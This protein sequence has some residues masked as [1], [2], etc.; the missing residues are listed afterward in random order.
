MRNP[1]LCARSFDEK[2]VQRIKAQFDKS[3]VFVSVGRSVDLE[4]EIDV[5]HLNYQ[6]IVTEGIQLNGDNVLYLPKEVENTQ[7]YIKAFEMVITK[8]GFGTVAETMLAKKK[9]AVIGRETVA[10][11]R[12]TVDHLV[13]RGLAIQVE[14][15]GG[16]DM[17]GI[18]RNLQAFEPRY[19][20]NPFTNDV[21]KIARLLIGHVLFELSSF[22]SLVPL[23]G[24]D[25]PFEVKRVF[26]LVDVEQG[27]TRENHAYYKTK[28]VLICLHGSVKVRSNETVYELND[29]KVGLYLAPDVW[30]E[31]FD[32]SEGCTVSSQFRTIL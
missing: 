2:E 4:E 10:E 9:C 32:F 28:Q 24:D 15:S 19:E 12:A 5:S 11:D 17:E 26:Y 14:Y 3:I 6:F 27:M 7:D 21:A 29:P 25:F 16:L 31:A 13:K 22:G 8:A 1:F 20:T 18:I 23:D 30:R